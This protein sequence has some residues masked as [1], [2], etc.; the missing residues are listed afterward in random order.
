MDA[1]AI[2]SIACGARCRQVE[3]LSKS[4]PTV[5]QNCSSAFSDGEGLARYQKVEPEEAFTRAVAGQGSCYRI[6]ADEH[7]PPVRPH[8]PGPAPPPACRDGRHSRGG[9]ERQHRE[10]ARDDAVDSGAPVIRV[11]GAWALVVTGLVWASV[12]NFAGSMRSVPSMT[13][14]E[15]LLTTPLPVAALWLARTVVVRARRDE[16]PRARIWWVAPVFLLGVLSLFVGWS[17]YFRLGLS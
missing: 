16:G 12:L 13:L 9:A 7:Q 4:I 15:A 2:T 5:S 17:L 11:I 10:A 1:R 3:T 6:A 14:S 8:S